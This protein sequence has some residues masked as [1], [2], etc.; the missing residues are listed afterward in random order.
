M[1]N[2]KVLN[3]RTHVGGL[4]GKTS[5]DAV[6]DKADMQV[7]A[8]GIFIEKLNGRHVNILVPYPNCT[9]VQLGEE[10]KPTE[11][12]KLPEGI[13]RERFQ[14]DGLPSDGETA[15]GISSVP[16]STEP[17]RRPGRPKATEP[18]PDAA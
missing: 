9:E 10:E 8:V 11:S 1:K 2:R 7:T 14:G 12:P 3:L 13:V 4:H 15:K 17:K 16:C 6:K 5:Y 18:G